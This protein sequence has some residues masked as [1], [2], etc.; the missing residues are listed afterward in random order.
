METKE[1]SPLDWCKCCALAFGSAHLRLLKLNL[2][3][4]VNLKV[5][6]KLGT[7]LALAYTHPEDLRQLEHPTTLAPVE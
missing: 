4:R 3:I 2:T 7:S 6:F 1:G 5:V